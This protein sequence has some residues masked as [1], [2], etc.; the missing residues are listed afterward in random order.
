MCIWSSPGPSRTLQETPGTAPRPSAGPSTTLLGPSRISP[1][2]PR[3][4]KVPLQ[5]PPGPPKGPPGPPPPAILSDCSRSS[6]RTCDLEHLNILTRLTFEISAVAGHARQRTW[7]KPSKSRPG[8]PRLSQNIANMCIFG[9]VKSQ[10]KRT[11]LGRV[12]AKLKNKR[13]IGLNN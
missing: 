2:P 5:D 12:M 10:V 7:I 8:D 4:P 13:F 1:R 11:D 6:C 3:I 9:H